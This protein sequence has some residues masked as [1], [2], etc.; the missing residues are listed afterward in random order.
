MSRAADSMKMPH[1]PQDSHYGINVT[2]SDLTSLD[3]PLPD[4][5]PPICA[6]LKY[7]LESLP[8][9]SVIIPFFNEAP[10]MLLR[11]LHSILNR[12]PKELLEEII[13]GSC[14]NYR[15]KHDS[16]K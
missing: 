3:R 14:L 10:T 11:N 6:T 1:R 13:L 15:N 5:R 9:V 12:S 2:F 4:T 7:D 8:K 16:N